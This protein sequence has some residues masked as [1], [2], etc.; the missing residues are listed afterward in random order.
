MRRYQDKVIEEA[1]ELYC[2]IAALG[3]YIDSEEYDRL[4]FNDRELLREQLI[5]TNAYLD[6]IGE[7][8][9]RFT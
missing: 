1:D 2:K 6:V 3:G 8:I 9:E 5:P 7:R 4:Q